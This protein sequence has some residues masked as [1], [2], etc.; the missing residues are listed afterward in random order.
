M[1]A[2]RSS[3]TYTRTMFVDITDRVLMER[4]KARL[5]AT[6]SYLQEEIRNET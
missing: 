1:V 6:N 5:K 4:E 3:G 2:A